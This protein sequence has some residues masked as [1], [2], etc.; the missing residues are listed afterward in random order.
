MKKFS[1]G[2]IILV[3]VVVLAGYFGY[4]QYLEYQEAPRLHAIAKSMKEKQNDIDK[5]EKRKR[6][7]GFVD[8][9][10]YVNAFNEVVRTEYKIRGKTE[11]SYLV[12]SSDENGISSVCFN[13]YVDEKVRLFAPI[14]PVS[15][16]MKFDGGDT[17]E[18]RARRGSMESDLCIISFKR[19]MSDLRNSSSL[20]VAMPFLDNYTKTTRMYEF[21]TKT[22]NEIVK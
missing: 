17:K 5:E 8:S 1:W 3:F 4:Q 11:N 9:S 10:E 13:A 21:N 7:V 12:I 19:F 20:I 6:D 18:Y 14:V 15:V 22:Y 16:Y 2:R